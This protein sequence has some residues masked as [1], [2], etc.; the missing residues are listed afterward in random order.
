[1]HRPPRPLLKSSQMFPTQIRTIF[2]PD[3]FHNEAEED[4]IVKSMRDNV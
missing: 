3:I 1:M 4:Y 2:T